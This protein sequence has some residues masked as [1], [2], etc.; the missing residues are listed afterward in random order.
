MPAKQQNRFGP[1]E[2]ETVEDESRT[3]RAY[4]R[5]MR[6]QTLKQRLLQLLTTL[7]KPDPDQ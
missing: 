4:R 6:P 5:E 2:T 7:P 3:P 1:R